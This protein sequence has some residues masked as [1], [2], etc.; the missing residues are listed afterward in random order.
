MAARASVRFRLQER[1]LL[2]VADLGDHHIGAQTV[3][4]RL[5]QHPIRALISLVKCGATYT[6]AVSNSPPETVGTLPSMLTRL[7]E[8]FPAIKWHPPNRLI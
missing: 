2:D 4:V 8:C 1:Q 3:L 5:G 7:P 6:V